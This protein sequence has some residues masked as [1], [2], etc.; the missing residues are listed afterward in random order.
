MIC[1]WFLLC[2]NEADGTV[3]HPFIGW[4]PTCK[5]CADKLGL[6]LEPE[7]PSEVCPTCDRPV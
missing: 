1:E 3:H 5:R 4:V 2:E 6:K 7:V